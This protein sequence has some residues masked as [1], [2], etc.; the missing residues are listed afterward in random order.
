MQQ[1]EQEIWK[2]DITQHPIWERVYDMVWNPEK[3]EAHNTEAAEQWLTGKKEY[4]NGLCPAE[5]FF[6]D[7]GGDEEVLE[8]MHLTIS[9][10][11][12]LHRL[13]KHCWEEW[14]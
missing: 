14:K 6:D 11:A 13:E 2:L 5:K 4:L 8:Y 7:D 9:K 1:Q 3:T 12:T 10:E